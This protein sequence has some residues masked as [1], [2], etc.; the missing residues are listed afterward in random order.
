MADREFQTFP[1]CVYDICLTE[2]SSYFSSK[3]GALEC[4]EEIFELKELDEVCFGLIFADFLNA[5]VDLKYVNEPSCEARFL[6]TAFLEADL[7][8]SE[9][10]FVNL[11]EMQFLFSLDFGNTVYVDFSGFLSDRKILKF[12]HCF[13]TVSFLFESYLPACILYQPLHYKLF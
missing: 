8:K 10:K 11:K 13:G 1:H 5:E 12:P 7:S 2:V 6:D 3:I 4:F 9:I